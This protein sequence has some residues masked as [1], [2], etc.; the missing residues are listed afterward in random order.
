[1]TASE[2]GGDRRLQDGRDETNCA[3]G[4]IRKIG[5]WQ[6]SMLSEDIGS[7]HSHSHSHYLPLTPTSTSAPSPTPSLLMSLMLSSALRCEVQTE[8]RCLSNTAERAAAPTLA[9]HAQA[10][11][12]YLSCCQLPSSL[13]TRQK[14]GSGTPTRPFGN[15]AAVPTTCCSVADC[16]IAT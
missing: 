1:M 8:V 7:L 15:W 13:E 10:A 16:S 4:G 14:V 11:R 3:A 12:R 2:R 6:C 5:H 9:S